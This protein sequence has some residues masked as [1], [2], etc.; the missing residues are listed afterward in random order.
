MCFYTFVLWRKSTAKSIRNFS[1]AWSPRK[2]GM[3]GLPGSHVS[4][5]EEIDAVSMFTQL[6]LTE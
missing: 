2:I 6:P 5:M 1:G 4:M 3:I